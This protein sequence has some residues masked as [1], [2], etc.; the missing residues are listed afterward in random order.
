[1]RATHS[2]APIGRRCFERFSR[3]LAP[4][5]H[6]EDIDKSDRA[7]LTRCMENLGAITQWR[8]SLSSAERLKLIHPSFVRRWSAEFGDKAKTARKPA[9]NALEEVDRLAGEVPRLK[10]ELAKADKVTPS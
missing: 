3:W 4:I 7:K 10:A 2:N 5:R 8:E 6:I 1:M 9:A